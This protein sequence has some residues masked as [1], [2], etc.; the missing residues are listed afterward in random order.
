M[1]AP[2]YTSSDLSRREADPDM[3]LGDQGADDNDIGLIH[4]N[5]CSA[6]EAWL[7]RL[8]S[9]VSSSN[10]KSDRFGLDGL[11]IDSIT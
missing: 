7:E 5:N 6:A 9:P 4:A 11:T 10:K 1:V 8:C 2:R 3:V